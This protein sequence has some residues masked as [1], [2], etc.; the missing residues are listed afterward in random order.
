MIDESGKIHPGKFK[1]EDNINCKD[2]KYAEHTGGGNTGSIGIGLC[3]MSGFKNKDNP[4]NY[5]LKKIQCEVAFNFI[6]GLCKKYKI[7][8]TP[9]NVFTHKE[10]GESHPKTSSKGKIDIC[11]LP[12]FPEISPDEMGNFIR[13]KIKWYLEKIS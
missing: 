13:S 9:M 8:V 6:A 3:G 5:P 11:Y 7:P 12:A 1:P 10:F 4:G 2:G